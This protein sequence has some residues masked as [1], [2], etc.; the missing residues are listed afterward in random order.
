MSKQIFISYR[1]EDSAEQT[2][3]IYDSLVRAFNSEIVFKD[4]ENHIPLGADFQEHICKTISECKVLLVVIGKNWLDISGSEGKRKIDDSRDFIRL[5]LSTALGGEALVVPLLLEN[6]PMPSEESLPENLKKFAYR[7]GVQLG[8]GDDFDAGMNR[9]IQSLKGSLGEISSSPAASQVE[10]PKVEEPKVEAP[11]VEAPKVEV[12]QAEPPKVETPQAAP[13]KVEVLKIEAPKV[14]A[15]PEKETSKSPT[16]SEEEM[17][18]NFPDKTG[19]IIAMV[20][21]RRAKETSEEKISETPPEL[22]ESKVKKT[23]PDGS[24]YMGELKDSKRHGKGAFFHSNGNIYNGSYQDGKMHGKGAFFYANGEKYFGEYKD[25]RRHG[26]GI[27]HFSSGNRYEG[28]YLDGKMHGLGVYHFASGNRYEGPYKEGKMSGQA[29]YYYANGNRH[30]GRYDDGKMNGQGTMY[31]ANKAKYVGEY[32]DGKKHGQGAD[33]FAN[34]DSYKGEYKDGKK[35]G[36]GTYYYTSGKTQK[37]TWKEDRYIPDR[38]KFEGGQ[39][40]L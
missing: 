18:A 9:L 16:P 12:P 22:D 5:E 39:F 28:P 25:D 2:Q 29:R 8:Q 33:F 24:K 19:E 15:P 1:K 17:L 21:G 35:H 6:T 34:G 26:Q 10:V 11:Q 38:S 36:E 13:P 32:K 31:Y 7:H 30:E 37:G 27:Y 40:D 14:E 20:P 23:Y 3:K 4:I